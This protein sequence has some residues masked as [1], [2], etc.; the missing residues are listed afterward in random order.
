MTR[1]VRRLAAGVAVALVPMA[2]VTVAAAGVASA[3]CDPNWSHNPVTNECKPPPPP[4][5]WWTPP[6][7]YAP[8]YA[9]PS[10]PPPP[11]PPPWA[12]SLRPVWDGGHQQWVWVGI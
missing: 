12:Q 8:M 1:F 4:P 9:P 7:E 3:E 2:P 6:P 10:A 11:P 5:D